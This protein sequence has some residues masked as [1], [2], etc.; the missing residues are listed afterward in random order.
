MGSPTGSIPG[1]AGFVV[2]RLHRAGSNGVSSMRCFPKNRQVPPGPQLGGMDLF[3]VASVSAHPCT[4]PPKGAHLNFSTVT[5][6][7]SIPCIDQGVCCGT[8]RPCL[9]PTMCCSSSSELPKLWGHKHFPPAAKS[10]PA[11]CFRAG[12][13][14]APRQGCRLCGTW[15]GSE[16]CSPEGQL[17]NCS[18]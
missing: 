18:Q 12:D 4:A 13:P 9:V 17:W 5:R 1:L 15:C 11:S 3:V 6:A 7:R 16:P 14:E 8:L 10:L 2:P